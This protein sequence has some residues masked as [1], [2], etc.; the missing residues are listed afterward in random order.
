MI[1]RRA[2]EVFREVDPD[3]KI[4]NGGIQRTTHPRRKKPVMTEADWDAAGGLE[5]PNCHNETVQLLD[6]LC[7]SCYRDRESQQAEKLEDRAERRYYTDQLRKGTI[8]LS[9]MKAGRLGKR[10]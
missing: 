10:V 1:K 4:I 9:D 5:C 3:L 8:R 7:P 6:G 2:S